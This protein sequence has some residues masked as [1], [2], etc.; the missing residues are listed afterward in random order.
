[1]MTSQHVRLGACVVGP[2]PTLG[3]ERPVASR[4]ESFVSAVSALHKEITRIK[5]AEMGRF[6]L[7]G[8][9]VMAL[10]FLERHPEGMTSAD[11]ARSIGVDRAAVSRTIAGLE[12]GGYVSAARDAATKYRA[13]LR[14]TARG[15]S[16]MGECSQAIDDIV[17]RATEGLSESDRST[18]YGALATIQANLEKIDV[19]RHA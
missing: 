4:F 3:E 8:T 9:D 17:A 12:A 2:V 7:K 18:M 5:A 11:L 10:Y 14:L 6:G 15:Q 13:P 19:S 1:M 16:V